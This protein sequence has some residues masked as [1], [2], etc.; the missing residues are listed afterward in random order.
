MKTTVLPV[1]PACRE[2]L[3][4]GAQGLRCR[5]CGR[6]YPLDDGIPVLLSAS[7][8]AFKERERDYHGAVSGDFDELH[9][10]DTAR[11]EAFKREYHD[12]LRALGEGSAVL[13]IGC[14]TGWDAHRLLAGGLAVY[15]SDISPPMAKKARERLSKWGERVRF[16]ICDAESIPFPPESF[17]GVLIT[18]ALH[19]MQSPQGCVA[20][21]AR[22]CR[23]GG[24]VVLGFEPTRWP[25]YSV[26]P[27]RR[28]ASIALKALKAFVR[29]PRTALRKARGVTFTRGVLLETKGGTPEPYSPG[30]RGAKGFS[31]KGIVQLLQGAG[32]EIISVSRVWYLNGFI[33]EFGFLKKLRS[34][35]PR[36]ESFLI[37]ADRA[38]SGIPLLRAANWHWNVIAKKP[39]G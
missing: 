10:L 9:D 4:E 24:L 36:V 14:G 30:D 22:V 3:L 19:H 17:D 15:L 38:L 34:P 18:A 5:R 35:S 6:D 37:A 28:L 12:R 8:G 25:Y 32:L 13:E 11:V 20:E 31:R 16:F 1:C 39:A 2:P 33:Q 27:A 21:M 29:S 23:P 26:L 7:I